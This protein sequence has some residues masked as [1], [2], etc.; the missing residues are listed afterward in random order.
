MTPPEVFVTDNCDPDVFIQYAENTINGACA[1]S[2]ETIRTWTATDACGNVSTREQR[3]I[4]GDTEAPLFTNV[5]PDITIDCSSVPEMPDPFLTDNCD[6]AIEFVYTEEITPGDCDHS[7]TNV[8]TWTAEDV[9]GNISTVSQTV[10]VTDGQAPLI[11]GAPADITINLAAGETIPD[12]VSYTH[13][14][15]P[16]NREV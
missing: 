1:G 10:Y 14:T 8:R 2:F 3:V 16:T 12:A 15:L 9:C 13:L 6:A 7:Y 11:I 4:V 5:P